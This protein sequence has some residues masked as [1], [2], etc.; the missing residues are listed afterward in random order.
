MQAQATAP[1][2]NP[3]SALLKRYAQQV[4][5]LEQ[6][7]DELQQQLLRAQTSSAQAPAA[8][9]AKSSLSAAAGTSDAAAGGEAELLE[10]RLQRDQAQAAA[11][12]LRSI[13]QDLCGD[14]PDGPAGS[15]RA[16]GLGATLQQ[17]RRMSAKVAPREAELLGTISNLKSA[18]EK[19][20]AGSGSNTKY[21]QMVARSKAQRR[22]LE[23][24]GQQLRGMQQQV[25]ELE[26]ARRELQVGCWRYG[27]CIRYCVCTS[28]QQCVQR[29]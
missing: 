11:A 10:L 15:S 16:S 19:A 25:Q 13:L 27:V 29:W 8:Q 21:M 2:T 5:S 22:E 4:V 17:P 9:P 26:D 7:R 6:E 12:R 23:E 14:L 24:A 1:V 20:V 28:I 18:L 3:D